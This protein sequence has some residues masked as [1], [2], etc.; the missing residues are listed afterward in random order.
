M[1]EMLQ[2][3]EA[4]A[5]VVIETGSVG[6]DIVTNAAVADAKVA[7]TIWDETV[8]G[9]QIWIWKFEEEQCR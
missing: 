3:E 1:S 9:L 6:A 4:L 5:I 7:M 8:T 2:K